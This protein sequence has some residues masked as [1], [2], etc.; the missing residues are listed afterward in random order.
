MRRT[1]E[2]SW[3]R[4]ISFAALI[5][6]WSLDFSRAMGASFGCFVYFTGL[7]ILTRPEADKDNS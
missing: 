7:H 1:D 3:L 5:L 4:W 2:F 6:A